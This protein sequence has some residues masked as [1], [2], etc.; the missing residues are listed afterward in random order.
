[1]RVFVIIVTYNGIN[2]VDLCVGKLRESSIALTPIV[3]DNA[4]P[5]GTAHYVEENYPETIL[6]KSKENLGFGRANN[7]G[8]EKALALGCDYVFLLNQDAFLHPEAIEKLLPVASKHPEYAILSPIHL[9]EKS[10]L[11]QKFSVYLNEGACPSFIY[12]L[13]H[14]KQK[15]VYP[16]QYVN[17]AGWLLS[18]NTLEKIGGFDPLFFM[19][20]EDS[21]YLKRVKKKGYKIGIVPSS[22]LTHYRYNEYYKKVNFSKRI[23]FSLRRGVQIAKDVNYPFQTNIKASLRYYYS[24]VGESLLNLRVF[25]AFAHSAAFLK[26]LL[27]LQI[28]RKHRKISTQNNFPFLKN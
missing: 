16:I 26:W 28:I 9:N 20:G 2:W 12:D 15:E 4:S 3:I 25:E 8:M 7:L 27:K 14:G 22:F 19:Y 1:M 5:D 21:E 24:S 23:I 11:D 17:A 6:I 10:G 13:L 18:N